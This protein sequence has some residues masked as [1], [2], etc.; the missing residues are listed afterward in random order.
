M[1]KHKS[2]AHPR[3]LIL[4]LFQHCHVFRNCDQSHILERRCKLKCHGVNTSMSYLCVRVVRVSSLGH[5]DAPLVF[6]DVVVV[7]FSFGTIYLKIVVYIT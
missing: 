7:V 4:A 6:V 1:F 3:I 2:R 5:V